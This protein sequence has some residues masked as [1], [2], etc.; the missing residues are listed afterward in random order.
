MPRRSKAGPQ[1]APAAAA[2]G[3]D[4]LF[5]VAGRRVLIAGAA[6]GLGAVLADALARRGALLMLA[7]FDLEAAGAL[8]R[9]LDVGA[10]VHACGLDVASES[11]CSGAIEATMRRLGGLDVLLNASG[12]YRVAPAV[13]FA[14]RDWDLTI[15]V[16]LTGAFQ[17]AQAAGRHMVAQRGGRIITIASVSSA[18]ANPEYAAYAASK[19][20][21]AH[22]TRVLA[23]E[24]AAHG[25]TVNAIGPAVTPT[26][27]SRPILD[28]AASRAAALAKIPMR[29]FGTP[30]DLVGTV[31][32]LAS[33]AG[34]F[35]TGQ[36]IYVDG[37]RTIA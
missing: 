36:T 19:A 4:P 18:V 6:G 26:A 37:G 8:A 10:R 24:W 22:L 32:L 7:D 34:A 23:R 1:D 35:I 29:R 33:D 16:N 13:D 11:A 27:L 28:D 5:D 3:V 14:R 25:V 20:G 21:V 15:G 17:L 12:V 30:E 31:V 9:R 2:G